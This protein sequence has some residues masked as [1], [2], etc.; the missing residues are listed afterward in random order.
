MLK[1]VKKYTPTTGSIVN[2][3]I[4]FH[5]DLKP[6]EE[7]LRRYTTG[8]YCQYEV[9]NQHREGY[10]FEGL[11]SDDGT[12]Y[13]V[14][15]IIDVNLSNKMPGLLTGQ[16]KKINSSA[17]AKFKDI[18]DTDWYYESVKSGVEKGLF[19]GVSETEFAPSWSL[20]RGMLV[21]I[22]YR[23]EN[24]ST[25]EKAQFVDVNPE[26]Y[27]SSPIAWASKNGIV[28]GVGEGKFS[29]EESITRQDLITIIYRYIMKKHGSLTNQSD[30]SYFEDSNVISYYAKEPIS[31]AIGNTVLPK[32]DNN[33]IAPTAA[34]TRAEMAVV[35]HRIDNI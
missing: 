10:V 8:Y 20:T 31:W 6:G 19:Q 4:M 14:G 1:L 21:T 23:Y 2:G 15:D 18:K 32:R 35:M 33:T 27:Y 12:L 29:P 3:M 22:L 7:P 34:A 30:V 17:I 25:T 5:V 9:C 26:M 28:N 11:R 16:W 24:A 13:K